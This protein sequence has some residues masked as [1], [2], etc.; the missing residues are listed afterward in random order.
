MGHEAIGVVEAIGS[1]VQ[2]IK[3][4]QLVVMPFA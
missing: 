2:R 1:D 3:R 4:G